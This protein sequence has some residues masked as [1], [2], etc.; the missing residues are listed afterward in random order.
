MSEKSVALPGTA[1]LTATLIVKCL[2]CGNKYDIG[3]PV[4]VT[5]E[6]VLDA[7]TGEFVQYN[8]RFTHLDGEDPVYIGDLLC[9]PKHCSV[10]GRLSNGSVFAF[11]WL[12]AGKHD[13]WH[14]RPDKTNHHYAMRSARALAAEQASK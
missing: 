2:K 5:M 3:K 4:R 1:T 12:V 11:P 9:L 13:V 6:S 8:V 14:S 10:F 7:D